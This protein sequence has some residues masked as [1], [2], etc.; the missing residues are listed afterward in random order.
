MLE[1]DGRFL[2]GDPILPPDITENIVF[3]RCEQLLTA[4]VDGGQ[5]REAPEEGFLVAAWNAGLTIT[6]LVVME[7]QGAERKSIEI[8]DYMIDPL[9]DT[10]HVLLPMESRELKIIRYR[11]IGPGFGYLDDRPIAKDHLTIFALA[12]NK[13]ILEFKLVEK[14]DDGV[15]PV[16]YDI[17]RHFGWDN[18]IKVNRWEELLS[19]F[20]NAYRE[21]DERKRSALIV[22]AGQR[23]GL[24]TD[25]D[26]AYNLALYLS[27][28]GQE[29]VSE[30]RRR[31]T[32]Y[33]AEHPTEYE[34]Y[35]RMFEEMKDSY[36]NGD[37]ESYYSLKDKVN[38]HRLGGLMRAYYKIQYKL[39][40]GVV[41][42]E[43][44]RTILWTGFGLD[45]KKEEAR[46][47]AKLGHK[48]EEFEVKEF[49]GFPG[50]FFS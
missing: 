46:A 16:A 30:N 17:E 13:N 39:R 28:I 40:K 35:L 20:I 24:T 4:K 2:R 29:M 14:S 31:I 3:K 37:E 41:Y 38:S 10:L 11:P 19:A 25:L 43:M 1:E 33:I 8:L 5:N 44:D 47:K 32:D 27:G 15:D 26:W 7:T 34:E 12:D 22:E 18:M 23:L 6:D 45:Y 42:S 49:P 50:K 48:L 21:T 9:E 36:A